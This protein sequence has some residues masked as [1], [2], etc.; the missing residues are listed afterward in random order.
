MVATTKARK[1]RAK[2]S[3]RQCRHS[4][5]RR[6]ASRVLALVLPAIASLSG[7]QSL[8]PP[9]APRVIEQSYAPAPAWLE[10]SQPAVFA[11]GSLQLVYKSPAVPNLDIAANQ[12]ADKITMHTKEQLSQ[13]IEDALMAAQPQPLSLS[14]GEQSTIRQTISTTVAKRLDNG[15]HILQ[16]EDYYYQ[17][18]RTGNEAPLAEVFALVKIADFNDLVRAVAARLQQSPSTTL[19]ALARPPANSVRF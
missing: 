17:R 2:N 4:S 3:Y 13:T 1:Y 8:G 7:C 16:I 11:D 19:R 12:L 15:K 5:S 10:Q 14:D 18:I 9:K 6:S